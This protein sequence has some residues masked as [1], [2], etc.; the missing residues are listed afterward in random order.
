MIIKGFIK[1]SISL[2]SGLFVWKKRLMN[3][4]SQFHENADKIPNSKAMGYL[5]KKGKKKPG[6]TGV[7]RFFVFVWRERARS[8]YLVQIG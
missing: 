8:L 3:L 1:F 5:P 7:P 6:I 4:F 2:I